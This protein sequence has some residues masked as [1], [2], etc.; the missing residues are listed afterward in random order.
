[1]SSPMPSID[2]H[3]TL[4]DRLSPRW[5]FD[6]LPFLARRFTAYPQADLWDSD[7][8]ALPAPLRA[9]VR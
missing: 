5:Q 7:T 9:G 6:A 3:L 8:D 1:M 4:Q 2:G